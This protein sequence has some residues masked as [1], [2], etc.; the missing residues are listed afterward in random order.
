MAIV[1]ESSYTI[2]VQLFRCTEL[3]VHHRT[4]VHSGVWLLEELVRRSSVVVRAWKTD[5]D[6]SSE[7]LRSTLMDIRRTTKAIIISHTSE[8]FI[9]KTLEQVL[10]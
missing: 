6:V 10:M 2:I 4:V 7:G 8:A 9:I 1:P 5:A 3:H